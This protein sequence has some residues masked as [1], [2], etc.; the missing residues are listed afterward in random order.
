MSLNIENVS[1]FRKSKIRRML[2]KSNF[3][4]QL[5]LVTNKTLKANLI[6]LK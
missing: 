6:K 5:N 4:L 2:V 3:Y 1:D